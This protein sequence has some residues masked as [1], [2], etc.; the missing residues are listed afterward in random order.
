MPTYYWIMGI[1]TV[2]IA[3]ILVILVWNLFHCD[4]IWEQILAIFVIIPFLLRL[5]FIK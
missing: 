4:D 1:Y 3:F 5:C 2:M